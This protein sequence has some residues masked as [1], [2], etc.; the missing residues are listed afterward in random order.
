MKT[1]RLE[2]VL[3]AVSIGAAPLYT[4]TQ[5]E[6]GGSVTVTVT[7]KGKKAEKI[8]RGLDRWAAARER[9]N[10]ARIEQRG[11]GNTAEA[12]QSGNGNT[13]GVYQRG[14]GHSATASQDGNN[15]A[16][17]VFQFGRNT[18]TTTSQTGDGQTKL[19]F[20]AGW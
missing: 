15:N 7:P 18:S 1:K 4:T 3:L 16:L 5:A 14:K 12:S 17:G 20:Q 13:L 8:R 9:R 10:A 11:Y 6:A 19:I 2:A